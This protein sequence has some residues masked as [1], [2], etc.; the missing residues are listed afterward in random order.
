MIKETVTLLTLLA[1]SLTVHAAESF[2]KG[3]FSAAEKSLL[4]Q[5]LFAELY[6]PDQ[7]S[8]H[9]LGKLKDIGKSLRCVLIN[10]G[11]EDAEAARS[12]GRS[13]AM[14]NYTPAM[15][16]QF[17]FAQGWEKYHDRFFTRAYVQEGLAAFGS[18]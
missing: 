14:F 1:A 3:P 2:S 17:L 5:N 16:E 15:A 18:H 9:M 12:E 8:G 10:F 11:I 7:P 6:Q 4:R 13:M